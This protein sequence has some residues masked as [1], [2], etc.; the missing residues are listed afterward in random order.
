MANST[1]INGKTNDYSVINGI[2]QSNNTLL[3]EAYARIVTPYASYVFDPGFGSFIPIWLNARNPL[4]IDT[5]TSEFER[6]LKI[7]IEQKRAKTILINS[8]KLRLLQ[9]AIFFDIAITDNSNQTF[10]LSSNYVA[11]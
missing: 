3:T 8:S 2:I 5:I 1:W 10:T 6:C 4:T 9:N 7:I 11:I